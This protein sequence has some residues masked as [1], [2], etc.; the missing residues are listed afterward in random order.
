MLT[1]DTKE[2]RPSG[3]SWFAIEDINRRA[4]R[5]MD[6]HPDVFGSYAHQQSVA[7]VVELVKDYFASYGTLYETARPATKK[8]PAHTEVKIMRYVLKRPRDASAF[9][10]AIAAAGGHEMVWKH[11][12]ESLSI[13]VW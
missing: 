8:R 2:T 10:A 5:A 6:L 4:E 9:R 12:T 3:A 13:H 7:Q 11:N 1:E